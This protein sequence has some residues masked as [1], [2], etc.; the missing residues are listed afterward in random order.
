M[1]YDALIVGAGPVGLSLA[2]LLGHAG[3]RVAVVERHRSLYGLPRAIRFDGEAM[4]LF[5]ELGILAAIEH[6]LVR[7]DEYVWYGAD[8]DAI[9]AIDT[10]EPAPSGW[11]MSYLFWQ[12]TLES[13]LQDA[14]LGCPSV[15]IQRPWTAEEVREHPDHVE[16][17]VRAG[18][19]SRTLTA[20]YLV[21]ADG[22]NS[23]VRR[24]CGIELEEFGFRERW[25][26][27]DVRPHDMSRWTSPP[28][29]A[30][31]CDPER[32]TVLVRNG[33]SHRRWEFMLLPG[34]PSEDFQDPA[35]A[36]ELLAPYISPDEGTLVR[37]AVYEFTGTLAR[38][39][40]RGRVVLAGDA[41]H[42][43]PPFMGE[44]LCSGQCRVPM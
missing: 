28:A 18:E 33:A 20:R 40:R 8:G 22:A 1:H 32:P 12:P 42:T 29:A 16:V 34:E 10:S 3:H 21:G 31:R 38:T 4:R 15:D 27:V 6:D 24:S 9:V 43:M 17:V 11:G 7:L 30:Q 37:Q 13:A 39:L 41:A 35:R 5:Q 36:W 44:G 25:L 26:V 23:I 2:T 14:A 19:E